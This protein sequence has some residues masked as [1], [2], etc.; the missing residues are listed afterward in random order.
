MTPKVVMLGLAFFI[1]MLKAIMLSVVVPL[2]YKPLSS[3]LKQ[4]ERPKAD[5]NRMTTS[6]VHVSFVFACDL[7]LPGIGICN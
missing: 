5:V 6:F 1:V 7:L 2:I 3:H 4:N